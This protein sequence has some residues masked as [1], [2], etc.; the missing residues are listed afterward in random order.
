MALV[1]HVGQ[2]DDLPPIP[3]SFPRCSAWS[4]DATTIKSTSPPSNTRIY[5]QMPNSVSP[6]YWTVP[7]A[8]IIGLAVGVFI[9]GSCVVT[10][11]KNNRSTNRDPT[12]FYG[13]T[14]Y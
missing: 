9:G 10:R 5:D 2:P 14:D 7:L 4:G 13:A 3:K 12:L 6:L 1:F 11:M 8:T